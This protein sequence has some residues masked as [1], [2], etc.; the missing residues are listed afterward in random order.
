MLLAGSWLLMDGVAGFVHAK[1]D[2]QKLQSG[3]L[4]EMS[5]GY[6]MASEM[7]SSNQPIKPDDAQSKGQLMAPEFPG[8]QVKMIVLCLT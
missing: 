4:H 8:W 5:S 1:R 6:D 7:A 3:S 2:L